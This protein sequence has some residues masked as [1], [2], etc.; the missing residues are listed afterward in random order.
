[1]GYPVSHKLQMRCF[2]LQCKAANRYEDERGVRAAEKQ[3]Q[4][5]ADLAKATNAVPPTRLSEVTVGQHMKCPVDGAPMVMTKAG[6]ISIEDGMLYDY[7]DDLEV[8]GDD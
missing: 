7:P 8:G 4:A 1:M 2:Y 6:P 5:L 3:A